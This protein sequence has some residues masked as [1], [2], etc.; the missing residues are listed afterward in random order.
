MTWVVSDLLKAI[1]KL[2][3]EAINKKIRE[4]LVLTVI[5]CFSLNKELTNHRPV[6]KII[7]SALVDLASLEKKGVGYINPWI[8]SIVVKI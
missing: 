1:L 8:Y 4:S 3:Q 2:I 5:L 7:K 6:I